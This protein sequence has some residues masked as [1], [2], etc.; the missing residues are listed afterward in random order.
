MRNFVISISAI[1][2][3]LFWGCNSKTLQPLSYDPAGSTVT[4]DKPIEH[5]Q[6]RT[7]GFQAAGIWAS[8]EFEGARLNDFRQVDDST[9]IAVIR[10]ENAPVNN[11]AWYAFRLWADRP[12][13]IRLTLTYEHGTHRYYPKIS[14]DGLH[15]SRLDSTLFS[16]D[17]AKGTATLRLHLDSDTLWV[18][19]QELITE[20]AFSRFLDELKQHHFVKIETI[21]RTHL[22]SPIQALT[23]SEA[24]DPQ[25]LV[26][27]MGRQ[28]PPEVTG[29]LAL[30]AFLRRICEDDEL[31][32]EFR[33]RYA[34]LAVP[35]M[36]PDG[37]NQGHWRHNGAGVDLNRDWYQFH[38]PETR[39]AADFFRARAAGK[40][41]YFFIDFHSTQE[42]VFYT[43]AHDLPTDPP[44]LTGRWLQALQKRRPDYALNEEPSGL[45]SPVS[46]NWFYETFHAPS[47]TYEVGDE[48]PR[49]LISSI[50]VAAAEALMQVLVDLP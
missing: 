19:A 20:R 34:V 49:E 25:R 4:T 16:A 50:A 9:Y 39:S 33:Q 46:K 14:R 42:D 15:W 21:G 47:V 45:G 5:Q 6:R 41:V 31:A 35:L 30:M 22:G 29:S 36:N 48:D 12:R 11:S 10:P 17:T 3:L 1:V 32:R 26:L 13:W 7:I 37:V 38:Q 23:L 18:S 44:E 24:E 28:H 40:K 27:V 2:A 8:N 43:L